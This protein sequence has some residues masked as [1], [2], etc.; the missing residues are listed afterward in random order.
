MPLAADFYQC[1]PIHQRDD[2]RKQLNKWHKSPSRKK[3]IEQQKKEKTKESDRKR[4]F[5]QMEALRKNK[6]IR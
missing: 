5:Q 3:Y 2:L 1:I 6:R 4:R